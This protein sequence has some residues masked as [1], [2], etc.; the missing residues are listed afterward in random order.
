MQW[1]FLA[2]SLSF[3]ELG[4]IRCSSESVAEPTTSADN[5]NK[6]YRVI[7]RSENVSM[8]LPEFGTLHSKTRNGM[9]EVIA[10]RFSSNIL[11]WLSYTEEEQN[12]F[13]VAILIDC[14]I[15]G[16]VS[17]KLSI[18]RFWALKKLESLL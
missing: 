2:F 6:Q 18:A 5:F 11:V 15:F 1:S 16:D 4:Y 14:C 9:Y 7:S 17:F 13:N 3:S 12:L 8:K 10:G